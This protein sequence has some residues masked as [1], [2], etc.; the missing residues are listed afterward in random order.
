[1]FVP[2]KAL[3]CLA[4]NIKADDVVYVRLR[5]Q[6]YFYMFRYNLIKF[7]AILYDCDGDLCFNWRFLT[8]RYFFLNFT[9]LYFYSIKV[10]V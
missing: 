8:L 5:I 6:T 4:R 7:F 1:M 10:I 3:L 9:Y 2:T